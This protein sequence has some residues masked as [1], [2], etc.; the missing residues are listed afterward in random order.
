MPRRVSGGGSEFPRLRQ[1]VRTLVAL[2]LAWAA[3]FGLAGSN[4]LGD[5][6]LEAAI[7]DAEAIHRGATGSSRHV[8]DCR[9]T[10]IAAADRVRLTFVEIEVVLGRKLASIGLPAFHSQRRHSAWGAVGGMF[11]IAQE[12]G[13][14]SK[15]ARIIKTLST[16]AVEADIACRYR[17][18]GAPGPLRSVSGRRRDRR[19]SAR[20]SL[21]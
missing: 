11:W 4:A 14:R 9:P 1:V 12:S 16:S 2:V 13:T 20:H 8:R 15:V 18:K 7:G 19:Q 10:S 17:R 5:P 21:P 3:D 6:Q